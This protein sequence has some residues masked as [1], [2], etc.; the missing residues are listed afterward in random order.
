M[1]TPRCMFLKNIFIYEAEKELHCSSNLLVQFANAYNGCR[2]T[3]PNIGPGDSI[4]ALCVSG[5]VNFLSHHP[6]L[7]GVCISR[8]WE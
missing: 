3:V 2:W 8:T 5:R 1:V 4:K 7:A 6:L